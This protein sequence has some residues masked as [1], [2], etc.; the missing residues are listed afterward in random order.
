MGSVHLVD[1]R[2]RTAV[3]F[4]KTKIAPARR[5]KL[6][7]DVSIAFYEVCAVVVNKNSVQVL[8]SVGKTVL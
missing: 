4:T 5:A 8:G 7:S 3:K 6:R 1:L 2:M